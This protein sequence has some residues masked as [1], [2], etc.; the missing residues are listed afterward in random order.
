MSPIVFTVSVAQSR[1]FNLLGLSNGCSSFS[2]RFTFLFLWAELKPQEDPSP[3]ESRHGTAPPPRLQQRGEAALGRRAA[4]SASRLR[5]G[6]RELEGT[7][8]GG[9]CFVFAHASQVG[10]VS[11]SI[12]THIHMYIYIY[13]HIHIYIYVHSKNWPMRIHGVFE[14]GQK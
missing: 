6:P 3:R 5:G 7:A 1:P 13:I 8:H 2:H 11:I 14:F 4:T 10:N 12:H 9:A